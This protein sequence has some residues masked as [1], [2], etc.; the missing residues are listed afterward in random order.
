[1][2]PVTIM[3]DLILVVIYSDP[4]IMDPNITIVD[5][6]PKIKDSDQVRLWIWI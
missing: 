3:M 6:N 2:D 4:I 5:P 1:M